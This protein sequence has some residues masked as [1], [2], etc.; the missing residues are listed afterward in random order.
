[1][2]KQLVKI[3]DRTYLIEELPT[4]KN[5]EWRKLAKEKVQPLAEFVGQINTLAVPENLGELT[6]RPE[7]VA[8]LG[9]MADQ[10]FNFLLDSPDKVIDLLFDYSP[11]LKKDKEYIENNAYDS[12]LIA[13]FR[14]VLALAFPFGAI[15]GK[16]ETPEPDQ[17]LNGAKKE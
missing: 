8:G 12:E 13:V 10:L 1:M 17:P 16:V 11:A 3:A 15:M 9:N 2:K 7:L 6:S 14:K 5:A 4:R